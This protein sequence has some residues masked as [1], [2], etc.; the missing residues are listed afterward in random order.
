MSSIFQSRARIVFLTIISSFIFT[1]AIQAQSLEE[2]VVTAQ[3]REQSLQEVPISIQA[4]TGLELTQQ[5]FRTM[6]D[7]GQFAPSVEINESLHEWSVTIRGMGND[8]A[9][10]SVEQSAPIF[11]DGIHFGRPSMIKGAFMDLERVEVLRG[12][13][14]V[15]FG[16]NATAGA[17][18]ITTKKP[19]D[20]WEGDLVTEFGN[21]G[22]INLEGGI[23]GPVND[24]F[25]FRLAGQW[26]TTTGHLIDAFR[27]SPFP[28]RTDSGVRL[29]TRWTPTDQ[30]EIISKI[31]YTRRRSDGDTNA[32]CRSIGTPKQDN[33]AVLEPGIAAY[34]AVYEH[35][36]MPNCEKDG[37]TRFG[38]QEG[39][40]I[41]PH[42]VDGIN[43]DDG[44][45]GLLDIAAAARNII[46]DGNITS[47]EP[48]DAY[49]Y[50]VAAKYLMDSGISV[51]LIGGL[52]DYQRDTFEASD[53]SPYLMEAAFRTENFDMS[54]AELRVTSDL[55]GQ[56]EWNAGLYFQKEDLRMD[57]V[58]TLRANIR[59][60]LRTHRPFNHSVWNSAFAG[61][62]F[63][64]LDDRASLDIGGRYSDVSKKGMI[65]AKAATWIFDID[66]DPDGDGIVSSVEHKVGGNKTRNDLA[67]AVI[68]CETGLDARGLAVDRDIS[69]RF[70]ANKQCGDYWGKAGYWTHEWRETDVPEAWDTQAPI[71]LGPQVFGLKRNN[72]PF[73]DTL[74]ETSFDPQV[75]LRF[76]PN[77]NHSFYLKWAE[78]FKAGGFDTSDRGMPRGGMLDTS[79]KYDAPGRC[80]GC[81]E[82]V[83][84]AEYATNYEFG[85]RG[86]IFDNRLRYGVTLFWQ[87]M[88][89]LQLETEIANFADLLAGDEVTGRFMT[90]A[91]GQ[92]TRGIE[93]DFMFAASE[94]TTL[95]LVGVIQ[96]GIMTEFIGGCTETETLQADT[97]D[98]WSPTESQAIAGSDALEGNIDRAGYKSPRT[99]DWKFII[100]IQHERP[101]LGG[102]Y[103]G[104]L[105][106][107]IAVSDEYS[108]DTL[109]FTEHM[110]WPVHSDI[111]VLLGIGDAEGTWDIGVYGRNFLGARQVYQ[112]EHDDE[113]RGIM[114]DDMPQSSFFNYGVQFNY[115][116]R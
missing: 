21:F 79:G 115:Y 8:V 6:E 113:P 95:N 89:D 94:Y 46:P 107:K 20:T 41:F 112:K 52:V 81:K 28:K 24:Q 86:S 27:G 70:V 1:P 3:R 103:T 65:T 29:T 104:K 110:I 106:S 49:N 4:V 33:L 60:P 58:Y 30:L 11:V 105:N 31:E 9:N 57:P 56:I 98:C 97:G 67:E 87:E 45:S 100:G 62:T 69:D 61:M 17:F 35:R 108:E 53:E 83:Y 73:R 90:N 15:Y 55:G 93:Y 77:D 84:K 91:G 54:S 43:N 37:F 19:T 68:S 114:T 59:R 7:L 99:P 25:A 82:F 74:H 38:V 47:R 78:A 34:D 85:A 92:R 51:E 26:D 5:G 42:P 66:P 96:R 64:F 88:D 16:Q 23:G 111:N 13:Q 102:R 36:T 101:I 48:L 75:T 63:N 32:V 39:T 76:R 80:T 71:A 22:R 44:R 40:G 14:P 2:I 109:G 116:F 10:M 72:G 12:P 18:S 50:R